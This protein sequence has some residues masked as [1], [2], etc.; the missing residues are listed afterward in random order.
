MVIAAVMAIVLALL[1][2]LE[3][4]P[5]QWPGL[6][7]PWIRFRSSMKQSKRISQKKKDDASSRKKV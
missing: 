3:E 1:F 4:N 7:N 6:A 2:Y 5:D